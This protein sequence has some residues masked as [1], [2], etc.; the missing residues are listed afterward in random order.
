[1][2]V[3]GALL[4]F[5]VW[6]A[7][8]R[9][10]VVR[11]FGVTLATLTSDGTKFA[12]S[13]LREKRFYFGPASACNIARLTTVPMPGHV[14]GSLLRGEAPVL[15]HDAANAT[16]EWSGKGYYVVRIAGTRNATEEIHLEPHPADAA[17]PWDKQ[18]MRVL[19]V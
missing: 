6:P 15:V 14:L 9:M 3:R 18:R 11:P 19:D 8:L 4:M 1:G 10:D 7:N 12:L 17:L 5:A 16:I 13:D 2:R